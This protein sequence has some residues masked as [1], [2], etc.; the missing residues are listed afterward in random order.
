MSS[1]MATSAPSSEPPPLFPYAESLIS[2]P[3]LVAFALV[4]SGINMSLPKLRNCVP[5]QC[6][7]HLWD[8]VSL[9]VLAVLVLLLMWPPQ[10]PMKGRADGAYPFYASI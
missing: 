2:A 5:V 3:S 4:A 9:E 7:P 6:H 10:Y 1:P 8:L